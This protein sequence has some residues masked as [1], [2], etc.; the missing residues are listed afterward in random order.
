[1][2]KLKGTT[3]ERGL[4][5]RR[6]CHPARCPGEHSLLP[7]PHGEGIGEQEAK[8]FQIKGNLF[9]LPRLAFHRTSPLF[10]GHPAEPFIAHH[11]AECGTCAASPRSERVS[12]SPPLPFSTG[13]VDRDAHNPPA[14]KVLVRTA[15]AVL[16]GFSYSIPFGRHG[17]AN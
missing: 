16:D 17:N 9:R 11:K 4:L 1:M 10:S 12:A 5:L 2:D 7:V 8:P 15:A 13:H 6:G 3:R 14:A